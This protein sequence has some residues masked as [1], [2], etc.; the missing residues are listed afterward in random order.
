MSE[1]LLYF[2]WRA[3]LFEYFS[4]ITTD[5]DSFEVINSGDFNGDSGPD[6]FNAKIR[7]ADTIW[8]GNV[9]MHINSS[10]W[11]NHGHQNDPSFDN[12]ILHVVV[13]NDKPAVNSKGRIIPTI[14]I[15]YP[16]LLEWNLMHLTNSG[17]WIPCAEL[18]SSFESLYLKM[19]LDNLVVERLEQKTKYV[20]HL[21]EGA[22]GS[23]EDAFYHSIARSFGLRANALP[24][25][26]LAKSIPL[27][28]LS[29]HKNNIF[30]LEAILFGQS[31]LFEE[32]I[33]QDEY[34]LSLFKEY[35]YLQHK[36]SLS[37]LEGHLWKFLRMRPIAFPT[38]RIAQFASL[39]HDSTSLFSKILEIQDSK[40]V[41]GLL[42]IEASDYWKTHYVFGKESKP[43]HKRLGK[44]S[45]SMIAL[46][47]LV[48]FIFAYGMHK[49]DS[50]LKE[51]AIKLLEEIKPEHNS[52]VL[53]FEKLGLTAESAY[54]SQAMIQL[55]TCYCD[56]KKC[57]YCHL[58]AKVLMKSIEIPNW[59]GVT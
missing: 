16:D 15:K 27:K 52:I 35:R 29:K 50:S 43:L 54:N 55:K 24:F 40:E 2:I 22:N 53:G 31:G 28:I 30:Q 8:A 1:D 42:Q 45:I 56:T 4:P 3:K 49:G 32:I 17:N 38:I 20:F 21:V 19:W 46:N 11:Y 34:S 26:L 39:I 51:K 6:F 41:I 13:A 14:I 5:G 58:G 57:L 18:F 37:P 25:E 9:E 44:E 48:P 10:D 36:F 7:I 59:N 47:S 23:W 33:I 12:V